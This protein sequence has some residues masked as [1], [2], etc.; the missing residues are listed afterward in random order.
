MKQCLKEKKE[1]KYKNIQKESAKL[2]NQLNQSI[3]KKGKNLNNSKQISIENL[4]NKGRNIDRKLEVNNSLNIRSDRITSDIKISKNLNDVCN[5]IIIK[6]SSRPHDKVSS[7]IMNSREKDR[8]ELRGRSVITKPQT[9]LVERDNLYNRNRKNLYLNLQSKYKSSEKD[10]QFTSGNTAHSNNVS[11]NLSNNQSNQYSTNNSDKNEVF[12]FNTNNSNAL[13]K[14]NIHFRKDSEEL[15]SSTFNNKKSYSIVKDD[16]EQQM[17]NSLEIE[18]KSKVLISKKENSK[19]NI[20]NINSISNSNKISKVQNVLTK[21][22]DNTIN[23]NKEKTELVL[24]SNTN[25][26]NPKSFLQKL[27]EKKNIETEF[28]DYNES[29][30]EV[31]L[32]PD[33][34]LNY[35]NREPQNYKKVKILGKGGCG[36][37]FLC[38]HIS[39][40]EYAIKQ[41][42][43]KGKSDNSLYDC[44]K[45]IEILIALNQG[46]EYLLELIDFQEDNSDLW[47]IFDL[48]G[49]SLGTLLF[50]IKG[51]FHN[52]ERVYSIKKG[53]L[54]QNLFFNEE[55]F[56]N[57]FKK[58]LEAIKYI[59]ENEI[60]HCDIKPDNI[61]FEYDDNNKDLINFKNLKLIDFGSAFK[62]DSPDNFSSNT[63]EYMPPE[64]T[65]LIERKA[66]SKEI[67]AFLKSLEK[68]PH[69]IDIWSL[70]VMILEIILS[71]P[72]WMSYKAKT[73]I[74]G[75]VFLLFRQY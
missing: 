19:S 13:N 65:E 55:N 9:Y 70:G 56:K 21:F 42:S 74:N 36:I 18:E 60:V 8:K 25:S 48:G 15:M 40:K 73:T 28:F 4:L 10:N 6:H 64:I 20:N 66:S 24:T 52:N 67:Y 72:V 3:T 27:D 68:L 62:I 14:S 45:E 30:K 37:V 39:G 35:G 57:F 46:H 51:E 44:K 69:V 71:C 22:S 31:E 32:T 17:L 61:L 26:K 47:L 1:T 5:N 75:K 58:L 49:K 29:E 50:K 11:N 41:V 2:S 63:P 43:K 16:E 54:Y 34:K 53:K 12:T 59:S 23:I 38:K 33:E 7:S